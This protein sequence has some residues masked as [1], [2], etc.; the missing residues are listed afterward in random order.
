MMALKA[1]P[2]L[3]VPARLVP[4]KFPSTLLPLLP[5]H[6]TIPD[7]PVRRLIT[8]PLIVEGEKTSKAW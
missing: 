7:P 8:T 5:S 3:T 4:K 1:F 2:T 6:N